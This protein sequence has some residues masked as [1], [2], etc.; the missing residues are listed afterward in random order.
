LPPFFCQHHDFYRDRVSH[1]FNEIRVLSKRAME[2]IASRACP[3]RVRQ[4]IRIR[5][6][7]E[8]LLLRVCGERLRRRDPLVVNRDDAAT[9]SL[10]RAW[11]AS[12]SSRSKLTAPDLER[13]ARTPSADSVYRLTW[14]L[15]LVGLVAFSR[16]FS[17]GAICGAPCQ[18]PRP[19]ATA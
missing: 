7:R 4:F 6:K 3:Q 10:D 17:D 18:V 9:D 14:R 11:A 5:T 1:V 13:F 12:A 15:P 16:F 2:F 19:Y 8:A